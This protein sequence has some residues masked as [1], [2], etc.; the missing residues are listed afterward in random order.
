MDDKQSENQLGRDA[1]T[2]WQQM[3]NSNIY[4]NDQALIHTIRFYFGDHFDQIDTDLEKLG[5]LIATQIEPLVAENQ[6]PSNLPR[7]DHYNSIGERID[8]IIHHPNYSKIGDIIYGSHLLSHFANPAGLLRCLSLFFLSSEAGEAGHNCPIACSAGIIRVLQ[9]ISEFPN[10]DHYLKKL[11]AP[12]YTTN[13]T[14][15]QFLTEIQ[16]GSDVGLNA[17]Q[18]RN[19]N[20]QWRIDGEKWFCSNANAEL[21]FVT[22]RYDK[23]IKGTKGL[24]LFLVP[25]I[26][27]DKRNH[28]TIRRLKDKIGTRTMATGEIDFNGAYAFCMGQ[29]KDG[30]RLV[31]ENVLH[32]SRLFNSFCV[33]AMARRA[34]TIA[35]AYAQ[36]RVAFS[37]PIIHYPSIKENLARIKSENTALLAGMFAASYLQEKHDNHH[38]DDEQSQLLLRLLINILKYLTAKWSIDHIHHALDVL[39]GNGTI[40]TFSSIPRLLR[41][42]IVCEN[43]EGTHNVLHM[44]V[45]KDMH[46]FS[47]EDVYFSYLDNEITQ[48]THTSPYVD[49]LKTEIRQLKD[50]V[51]HFKQYDNDLQSLQIHF[52]V[53][54][55]AIVFCALQLLKE[56]LHQLKE[57]GSSSKLDCLQYFL[58]L[59]LNNNNIMYDKEYLELISRITKSCHN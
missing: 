36:C 57:L 41:D 5:A 44:Q 19:E 9:K 23:K 1:L 2:H 12:S 31:I 33:V 7:I 54:K 52:I 25:A 58:L 56:A 48:F 17:T 59:R 30:F 21:F 6:L 43:W 53:D 50:T 18:A 39:A 11:I 8:T 27:N 13:F 45:L 22:A 20:N 28:F 24:G 49:L 29:P 15:A 47:I 37:S 46:K 32:I 40:E 14:G 16:G 35:Y 10:K 3:I 42:A 26:W 55:M 34:F 51:I 38:P 4:R